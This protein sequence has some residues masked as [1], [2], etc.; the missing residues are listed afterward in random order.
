M[1]NSINKSFFYICTSLLG[2][3]LISCYSFT[4][5]SVPEHLKKLQLTPVVDNSGYG[6][7]QFRESLMRA[8]VQ[9]FRDDNSFTLTDN[10][11]DARLSIVISS[12]IDA[13][14][15]VNPGELETQRKVTVSFK[16][17]YFDNVKKKLI[18]D[19]SFSNYQVY[20]VS[21]IL[22]NRNAG[23]E[24]TIIQTTDDILL[25]VVSGW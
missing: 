21:N 18:W 6:N 3:I 24:K 5:G 7:P 22:T 4:G 17:E 12:I 19:K 15:A 10:F 1:S 2:L 13:T 9:R 8:L 23:I 14:V 25:S 16:A 20:D 11:G